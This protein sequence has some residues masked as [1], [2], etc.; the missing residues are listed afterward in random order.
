MGQ[1]EILELLKQNPG[2][3]FEAHEIAKHTR[4]SHDSVKKKLIKMYKFE[5][6]WWI[7]EET[8]NCIRKYYVK[9]EKVK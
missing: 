1:F 4:M 9:Y 5:N 8:K 6:V 7:T 2:R 3:E